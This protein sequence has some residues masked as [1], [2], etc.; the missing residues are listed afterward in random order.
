MPI[1]NEA[2]GIEETL[3]GLQPFRAE[4]HEVIIVDGGSRDDSVQ[5]STPLADRVITAQRGRSRQM[6]AGAEMAKGDIFL[7]LHGDTFLPKEATQ[8]IIHGIEEKG[9]GWGH[10]DVRLSGKHPI[11][12]AVELFM[13]WRSRLTGIATGDQ[14][15]FVRRDLFESIGGFPEISL[16][17][18]IALSK[19]LKRRDPP[20]CLR[21]RVLTSSRRW[22]K[23]GIIRTILQMWYLRLAYFL[24]KDPD[25]LALIYRPIR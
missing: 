12:R 22:E 10:F 21:E 2:N 19:I 15:I 1:L 8:R 6:N 14:A 7:F 3:Y 23:N 16:M 24:G 4:G 5:L 9:R 18:D 17:E 13:N 20:L 25:Q 11:L